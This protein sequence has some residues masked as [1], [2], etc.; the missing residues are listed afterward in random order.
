MFRTKFRHIIGATMVAAIAFGSVGV[1]YSADKV[2]WNFNVWGGQR[3]FTKG[4]EIIKEKLEAAGNGSFELKINYGDALVR[5]RIQKISKSLRSRQARF[6][7][8]II[9]ANIHCFRLW[10]CLSCYRGI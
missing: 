8:V 3:A 1:A 7:S 4:I 6:V 9:L 5:S 2:V 10:S